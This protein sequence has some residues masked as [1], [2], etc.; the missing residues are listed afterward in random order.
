MKKWII[1]ASMVLIGLQAQA[2]RP[3]HQNKDDRMAFH[4]QMK[5]LKP[6]QRAT[7]K[8]KKMTLELD[9]DES[10]ERQ[11][12]QLILDQE[13]EREGNRPDKKERSELTADERFALMESR[14]DRQIAFKQEMKSILS[15][16]QWNKFEQLEE[17][18]KKRRKKGR[19]QLKK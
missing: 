5:D 15:E 1:A 4:Q 11:V 16:A 7:L 6:E 14:L 10:Q 17:R 18:Q 19:K 8:A 13:L 2:Q 12:E 9:L 3:Q